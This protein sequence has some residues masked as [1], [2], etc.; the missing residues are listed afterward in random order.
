MTLYN[1]DSLK[2]TDIKEI[3]SKMVLDLKEIVIDS[4]IGKEERI[5][6][7]LKDNPNPYFV[8][9]NDV[10]IKM[11]F[12][13]NDTQLEECIERYLMECLNDRL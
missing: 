5:R 6:A 9:H 7:Y 3:D 1:L 4:K 10:I 8:K 13:N 11:S 12:S 2:N